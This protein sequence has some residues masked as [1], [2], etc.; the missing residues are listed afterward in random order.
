MKVK[1][2]NYHFCSQGHK[3]KDL[4]CLAGFQTSNVPLLLPENRTWFPLVTHSHSPTQL[5]YTV[6]LS[7]NLQHPLCPPC[8]GVMTFLA[9]S[10]KNWSTQ[11][12]TSSVSH[13]HIYAS[14][15]ICTI[16]CLLP[17]YYRWLHLILSCPLKDFAPGV[18]PSLFSCI[19]FP[20]L[21]GHFHINV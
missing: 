14:T 18:L 19:S 16:F 21:L 12:R 17:C 3:Q 5:F 11:G 6:S 9:S 15:G 2:L 4:A 7:S 8:F 20:S 10:V 13:N 1:G